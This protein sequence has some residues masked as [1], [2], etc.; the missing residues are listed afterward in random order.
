MA[1]GHAVQEMLKIC[2][3]LYKASSAVDENDDEDD[4]KVSEASIASKINELRKSRGLSM[5]L[6]ERGTRLYELLGK[7]ISMRDQRM[8]VLN[9]N[10]SH[11]DVETFL[12]NSIKSVEFDLTKVSD[13]IENVSLDESNLDIKIEKRKED[14]ERYQKRLS[15]LKSVRYVK[16]IFQKCF[17]QILPFICSP[18]FMDEFE[19]LE[20]ELITY[21]D[22]YVL[23]FR[24]L[25]FL[26][27]QLEEVEK[28]EVNQIKVKTDCLMF[29][30]DIIT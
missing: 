10:L 25:A 27:Q 21:Y 8:F 6:S 4:E 23:K 19:K 1:D 26:E 28:S 9:R 30:L 11:S 3:F 22:L 5:E 7:E 16:K 29:P 15:A 13:R 2:N 24:C 20:Q 18:A 17:R 12:R 14:L